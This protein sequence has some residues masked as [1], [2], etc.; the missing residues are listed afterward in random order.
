MPTTERVLIDGPRH[1]SIQLTNDA[2]NETTAVTKV[3]RDGTS[4]ATTISGSVHTVPTKTLDRLGIEELYWSVD[5]YADVTLLWNFNA[6]DEVALIL[7]A[8]EGYISYL[9]NG[10]LLPT[11]AR[12]AAQATDGDL[13][14][15]TGDAAAAGNYTLK[16][17]LRKKWV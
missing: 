7:G 11:T 4:H 1:L 9:E 2:E 5:G 8:G 14:V 10:V 16:I 17:R 15:Q 13:Q 3:D 6:G 12:D